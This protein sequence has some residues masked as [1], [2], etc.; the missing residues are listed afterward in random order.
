MKS[1][2]FLSVILLLFFSSG[3]VNPVSIGEERNNL[4]FAKEINQSQ[5]YY[6]N[7]V[8]FDPEN[9]TAWVLR[10]NYYNDAFN[11]YETALQSYNKAIEIDPKNGYAWYSKGITLQNMHRLNESEVCFEKA[12]QYGIE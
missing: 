1:F 2:L 11:Q 12:K 9:A 4:Q 7:L 6:D 5:S 10:G 8:V 3:C